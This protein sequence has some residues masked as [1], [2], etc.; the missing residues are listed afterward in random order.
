[1]MT[2]PPMP[3]N[4]GSIA[5]RNEPANVSLVICVLKRPV[6]G[7]NWL[8]KDSDVS[9]LHEAVLGSASAVSQSAMTGGRWVPPASEP[10][11]PGKTAW[12]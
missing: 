7:Y 12:R 5:T 3:N 4:N 2:T 1:M 6:S 9:F 10:R 11:P 8:T